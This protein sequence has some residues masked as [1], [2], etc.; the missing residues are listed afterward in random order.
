MV[1]RTP[2]LSSAELAHLHAEMGRR[3]SD[4]DSRKQA[5]QLTGV[6]CFVCYLDLDGFKERVWTAPH[7]LFETYQTQRELMLGSFF[8]A[9][10]EASGSTITLNHYD[11]MLWPYLFSDS[12]FFATI[13]SSKE[14]LQQISSVAAG[15]FMRCWEIGF[16]AHGA[17][18]EG[19]LWWRPDLQIV[20]GP[21]I[22]KAYLAA[23]SMDCFGVAA[24]SE[25]IARGQVDAFTAPYKVRQK[26]LRFGILP[27]YKATSFCRLYA[28]KTNRTWNTEHYLSR[29]EDMA[30]TYCTRPDA[31]AHVIARYERSKAIV[32][33]MVAP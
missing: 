6:N 8:R 9:G 29:F 21:G 10:A 17:I 12:W 26:R 33:S 30:R 5:T 24:H 22:A 13:D 16:P 28:H 23:E 1:D 4:A 7:D 31:K 18:A 32:A 25:L 11:K 14:A 2:A 15:I 3:M 19:P 27:T 20:L